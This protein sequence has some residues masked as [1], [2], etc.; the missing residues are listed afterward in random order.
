MDAFIDMLPERMIGHADG[1]TFETVDDHGQ[2]SVVI[3]TDPVM[4]KTMRGMVHA[5]AA[6]ADQ[7]NDLIVDE[8]ILG[9]DKARQYRE[10]LSQHDVHFVGLFAPLDI[11]EDRERKRGDRLIGLARWQYGRVHSGIM[12]DLAVDTTIAS[13]LEC[14]HRI[15]SAF[16]L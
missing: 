1:V 13:S 15:R 4:Q 11:L 10:I 5:I 2:P 7:G 16:D 12:Y 9:G 3:K 8:V 14:A 6:L